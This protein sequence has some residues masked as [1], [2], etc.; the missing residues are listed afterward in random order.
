MESGCDH[1]I[2]IAA[3]WHLPV[4]FETADEERS[5]WRDLAL[6]FPHLQ[7]GHWDEGDGLFTGVPGRMERDDDH[8][9][10]QVRFRLDIWSNLFPMR[11]SPKRSSCPERLCRLCH[12]RFP[13][14]DFLKPW[15]TWV[16]LRADPFLRPPRSLPTRVMLRSYD[17]CNTCCWQ[18]ISHSWD[19]P[20][21]NPSIS[22]RQENKLSSGQGHLVLC[23]LLQGCL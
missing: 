2:K 14:P 18:Y 23:H 12:R 21:P 13:S 19:Q 15:V 9:L 20:D 10:K 3:A 22:P 11:T 7:G 16:D 6:A 17:Y 8:T 5:L 4:P 1:S